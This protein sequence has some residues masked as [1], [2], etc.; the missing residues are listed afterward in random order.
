MQVYDTFL[1]TFQVIDSAAESKLYVNQSSLCVPQCASDFGLDFSVSV[2]VHVNIFPLFYSVLL[3][4]YVNIFSPDVVSAKTVWSE[5]VWRRR[6]VRNL[7]PGLPHVS[8]E[9]RCVSSGNGFFV[10]S[11]IVCSMYVLR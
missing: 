5:C 9:N 4:V 8:Q 1:W 3:P 2:P 7:H 10:Q 11:H 6:R